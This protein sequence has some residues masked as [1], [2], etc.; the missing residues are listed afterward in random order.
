[1]RR[2][3][4]DVA[5]VWR[6]R[7][8]A[9]SPRDPAAAGS[10]IALA[11]REA[12]LAPPA[13]IVWVDGPTEAMQAVAFLRTPPLVL[14][15][16]AAALAVLGALGW[17][18]LAVVI[19]QRLVATP[20]N[21]DVVAFAATL[22]AFIVVLGSLRP[23]PAWPKL[24]PSP[25]HR[26]MLAWGAAIGIIA[27]QPAC[28]AALLGLTGQ[29]LPPAGLLAVLPLA[30]LLGAL[31]GLLLAARVYAVWRTLPPDLQRLAPAAP[32]G[33]QLR[34]ARDEAWAPFRQQI[35]YAAWADRLPT[36]GRRNAD[37][38]AF[39][40]DPSSAFAP[41]A[42][43]RALSSSGSGET[44][45]LSDWLVRVFEP[46]P[47]P[48]GP[49]CHLDG[50]EDATRAAA[51][52][53]FGSGAAALAFSQLAFHL[54]RLYPYREV[55][56][57]VWPATTVRHDAEERLHGEHGP[58]LA[59]GDGTA[60]YLWHG[61]LIDADLVEDSR[62]LSLSRIAFERDPGRRRVLIERFGLGRFMLECGA[63][64]LQRDRCGILYRLEQRIDEPILAVRVRNH[65]PHPDGSVEEFW[66]RVPPTTRTAR[67]AVAWTFGLDAD[68][69]DPAW[70]S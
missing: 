36:R 22:S 11:Y 6:D 63:I 62:P 18:G 17:I 7:L 21:G 65:T 25:R 39:R 4:E 8:E 58:A 59:W 29:A 60:V 28:C 2:R 9:R 14:W 35:L 57:A 5:R 37:A 70:Q 48:E 20:T 3:P 49:S 69:Y 32:V 61:Q 41:D 16:F 31:P 24:A 40:D 66:L 56:V 38:L 51:V 45:L 10:A 26:E 68:E 67:E 54:D 42:S 47:Q 27:L 12:G 55:A 64:E 50:I 30:G 46:R 44:H 13:R 53:C 52:D 15:R 19:T 33:Y 43:R 1:M 34:R 23:V